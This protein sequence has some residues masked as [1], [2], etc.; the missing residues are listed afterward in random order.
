MF[1][2]LNCLKYYLLQLSFAL[3]F[4]QN[5]YRHLIK[6]D[7]LIHYPFAEVKET[8]PIQVKNHYFLLYS[9]LNGIYIPNWCPFVASLLGENRIDIFTNLTL[10]LIPLNV[11]LEFINKFEFG[12]NIPLHNRQGHKC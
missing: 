6:S 12:V 4:H 9:A 3:L 8:P 2:F 11:P 5:Y 10:S 1:H 7:D